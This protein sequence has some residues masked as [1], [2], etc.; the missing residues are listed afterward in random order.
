VISSANAT[1]PKNK[2]VEFPDFEK[3]TYSQTYIIGRPAN[4]IRTFQFLGVD[5]D[6]GLYIFRDGAGGITNFPSSM[7]DNLSSFNPNPKWYGG[8]TNTVTFKNFSFEVLFQYVNQL[9]GIYKFQRNGFGQF[10]VNGPAEVS[11]DRW[12]QKGDVAT[13]AKVSTRVSL[14]ALYG[15]LSD[16]AYG[17]ASFL[18]LKN[19][20]LSYSLRNRP[21]SK[22][23]IKTVRIYAL[24]QNLL[25]LTD[26]KGLDPENNGALKLPPLRM[27]TLGIQVS[28]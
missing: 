26:Y 24:G 19:A 9:G 25:T 18:R 13:F 6:T 22:I 7:T 20:S 1:I 14:P 5:P 28:L 27:Y 4:I 21:L 12:R 10:N 2:L 17:D 23:G 16:G 15:R 3:S 11:N 8:I